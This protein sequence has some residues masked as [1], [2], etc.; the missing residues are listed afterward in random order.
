MEYLVK[1]VVS[2]DDVYR[3]DEAWVSMTP[4]L[5]GI[6][7]RGYLKV[8]EE[9]DNGADSNRSG[10]PKTGDDSSQPKRATRR[11]KASSQPS[12]DSDASGHGE[13]EVVNPFE[14]E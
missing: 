11:R 1:A 14:S 10:G 8:L 2:F 5:E 9:R 6:I 7:D 12:E 3:G 4:R 13:A